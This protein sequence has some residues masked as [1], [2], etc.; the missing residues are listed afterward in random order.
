MAPPLSLTG[1]TVCTE[2]LPKADAGALDPNLIGTDQDYQ[3]VRAVD[4]LR[5]VT[6]FKKLAAQ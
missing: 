2:P 4:L 3:L 1:N 5:G 6:L